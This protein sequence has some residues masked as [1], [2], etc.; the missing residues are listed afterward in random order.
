M[1]IVILKTLIAKENSKNEFQSNRV[2]NLLTILPTGQEENHH[3]KMKLLSNML[4]D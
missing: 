2:K 1:E 3:I 4:L